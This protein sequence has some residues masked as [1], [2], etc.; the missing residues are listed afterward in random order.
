MGLCCLNR[1]S[2]ST[3]IRW[4]RESVIDVIFASPPAAGLVMGWRVTQELETGSDH[5]YIVVGIRAAPPEVLA[6]QKRHQR[7]LRRWALTKIEEDA[8]RAA[9]LAG[10]WPGQTRV[11][12][13]DEADWIGD[14][15][16]RA[17]DASM[18]RSRPHPRRV[19]YWWTDEIADLRRL[20]VRRR[21][22]FTRARNRGNPVRT[23][24]AYE[25]FR[26]ARASLKAAIRAAKAGAWEEL[27]SS[28]DR[29]P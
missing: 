22:K 24:E 5:L 23:G 15:M 20:A 28:L 6:R 25:A 9:V 10:T 2:A 17:C 11:G 29:D 19:A 26:V 3:C 18:P 16:E 4:Q 13:D 1:G 8:L 27:V 7:T 21:R 12:I 14:I